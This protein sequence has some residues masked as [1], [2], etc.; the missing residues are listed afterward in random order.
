MQIAY[1]WVVKHWN[2][3]I[4][5]ILLLGMPVFLRAQEVSDYE[6][7]ERA[8]GTDMPL[9]RS[10]VADFYGNYFNGTYLADTLGFLPGKIC[11]EG[12]TYENLSLNL[13]AVLQHV[14]LQMEDSPII[15]DL[16]RERVQSFTRGSKTYVN[17]PSLGYDLPAG[18][19]ELMAQ[20]S[21][22]V[23][24]RVSK[25][26]CHLGDLNHDARGYIGYDDP[27]YRSNLFDYYQHKESWYWIKEDGA[28]QHL[29]SKRKIR[30][31][32]QT[33]QAYETH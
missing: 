29:R 17:L 31:A 21:G 19:Y 15:L 5:V 16:G 23:Y 6:T 20:G 14:L 28:V 33:V 18:F 1:F 27:G 12:K 22:A 13:D 9:L 2:S 24:K 8:A 11:F 7:Y 4:T 26:L 30:A 3:L 10:R 32:I 25:L